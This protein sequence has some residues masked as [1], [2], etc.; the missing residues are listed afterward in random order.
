MVSLPVVAAAAVFPTMEVAAMS[1]ALAGS[2][3]ASAVPAATTVPLQD[4]LLVDGG[5]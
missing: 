4:T 5:S 1:A 3:P 2:A